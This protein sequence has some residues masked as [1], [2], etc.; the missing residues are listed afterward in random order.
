LRVTPHGARLVRRAVSVVERADAAFF[1]PIG[2]LD[3]Y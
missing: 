2:K 3:G 1:A